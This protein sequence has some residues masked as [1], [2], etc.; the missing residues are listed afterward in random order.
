MFEM[1]GQTISQQASVLPA[2]A[3]DQLDS[4]EVFAKLWVTLEMPKGYNLKLL[5]SC[6]ANKILTHK[7]SISPSLVHGTFR[8]FQSCIFGCKKSTSSK[9]PAKF[10][11]KPV[12]DQI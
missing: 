9:G 5:T 6:T 10:N 11:A 4:I 7:S 2:G 3:Q 12:A 8:K 1:S